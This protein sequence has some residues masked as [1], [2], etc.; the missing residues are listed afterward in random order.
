MFGP[1]PLAAQ[2]LRRIHQVSPRASLSRSGFVHG[3]AKRTKSPRGYWLD[4]RPA[5]ADSCTKLY[6]AHPHRRAVYNASMF[7]MICE[8]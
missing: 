2:S 8:K 4:K 5:Q 6:P 3:D 1:Q 7:N